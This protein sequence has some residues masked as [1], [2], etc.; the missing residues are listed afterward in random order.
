MQQIKS[1]IFKGT[2]GGCMQEINEAICSKYAAYMMH[3]AN[4]RRNICSK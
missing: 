4:K 2:T 3:V 1:I